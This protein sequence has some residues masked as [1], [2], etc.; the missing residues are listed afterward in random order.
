MSEDPFERWRLGQKPT[1]PLSD[2]AD[3]V[4]AARD[5]FVADRKPWSDG[6]VLKRLEKKYGAE[7][8]TLSGQAKVVKGE[9]LVVAMN[10]Y[11]L[12]AIEVLYDISTA[13]HVIGEDCKV[14]IS[15]EGGDRV[16]T[17]K[18][19]YTSAHFPNELIVVSKGLA[20][21]LGV[22]DEDTIKIADVIATNFDTMDLDDM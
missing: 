5:M 19:I 20:Q 4:K 21:L 10:N 1:Q 13:L 9:K 16:E 2:V 14:K 12:G 11:Q 18:L 6:D 8:L 7:A 3:Y 15:N 22:R 17:A